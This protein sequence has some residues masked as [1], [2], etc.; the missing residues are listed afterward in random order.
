MLTL[1]F[2]G[3]WTFERAIGNWKDC[4]GDPPLVTRQSERNA[5]DAAKSR[6][7]DIDAYYTLFL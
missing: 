7:L 6:K 4:T 5:A 1:I 2:K 3:E